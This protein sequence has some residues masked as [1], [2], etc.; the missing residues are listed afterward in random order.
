MRPYLIH[1]T[2]RGR[3]D[4]YSSVPDKEGNGLGIPK[5]TKAHERRNAVFLR[6]RTFA[7]SMGGSGREAQACRVPLVFRYSNPVTCCPPRLES[8]RG[9]IAHQR[10]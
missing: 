9:F 2:T 6:A 5:Y 1:L 7:S 3:I 4:H 8:G 10:G